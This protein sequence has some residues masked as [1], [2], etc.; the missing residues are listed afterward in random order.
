AVG[1]CRSKTTTRSPSVASCSTRFIPTNPPP[2]V[3]RA[4][5]ASSLRHPVILRCVQ[6]PLQD[7]EQSIESQAKETNHQHTDNDIRRGKNATCIH[8]EVAK[9]FA[10]RDQLGG[11]DSDPGRTEGQAKAGE[12][13]RNRG[14]Q[15][16][17]EQYLAPACAQACGSS[18][19]DRRHLAYARNC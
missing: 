7:A 2:P 4:V 19:K 11:D 6:A 16:N 17:G 15:H 14:R 5:I 8:D 13:K 12:K 3:T 10:G 9:S 18:A 1:N